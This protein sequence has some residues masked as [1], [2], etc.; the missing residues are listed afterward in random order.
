MKNADDVATP[1]DAK[2]IVRQPEEMPTKLPT[3]LVQGI[4]QKLIDVGG[5]TAI[6]L[7]F[8]PRLAAFP[9]IIQPVIQPREENM[10]ATNPGQSLD[11][12]AKKP[13][14]GEGTAEETVA[15][16]TATS[17]VEPTKS[18][19]VIDTHDSNPPATNAA[20]PSSSATA[21]TNTTMTVP[22]ETSQQMGTTTVSANSYD[23]PSKAAK[24]AAS[25]TQTQ[26]PHHPH[27]PGYYGHPHHPYPGYPYPPPM[28][29]PWGPYGYPYMHPH[30]HPY[31][32]PKDGYGSQPDGAPPPQKPGA[33]PSH[34]PGAPPPGVTH[35]GQLVAMN[36]AKSKQST[37]SSEQQKKTK[38]G[39][40]SSSTSSATAPSNK[41]ATTQSKPASS[42]QA[43]KASA[44]GRPAHYSQKVQAS[45]GGPT[46]QRQK[47]PGPKAAPST[48]AN[49][50]PTQKRAKYQRKNDSIDAQLLSHR[51][52]PPKTLSVEDMI[53][54]FPE[55]A[56]CVMQI[57]GRKVNMDSFTMD[58]PMY[59]QMRAWVQG[60]P[61]RSIPRPQASVDFFRSA[62]KPKQPA[63]SS[64]NSAT[65]GAPTAPATETEKETESNATVEEG[66]ASIAELR[67][68]MIKRARQV[69][70]LKSK[71]IKKKMQQG[72]ESLRQKGIH[73]S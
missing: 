17:D 71:G 61:F 2:L 36:E 10:S 18:P 32:N 73:I 41:G 49:K 7:N 56:S 33:P 40:S 47:I 34:H 26:K 3:K 1:H 4:S 23:E 28:M 64:L 66:H 55:D 48:T 37:T 14:E 19:T 25:K 21:T 53:R 54:A 8:P 9:G 50:Q 27:H 42:S 30:H 65:V 59:P 52:E 68:Q 57:H 58:T 69:R 51:R 63:K 20:A 31:Y 70:K 46:A 35:P 60:D 6:E 13:F 29:T 43:A 11:T 72:L 15:K 44:V 16:I 62:A 22:N 5:G 24:P 45:V 12:S 39:T 38:E 67:N